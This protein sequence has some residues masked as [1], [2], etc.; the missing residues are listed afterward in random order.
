[1]VHVE[2]MIS[3]VNG[4][5]VRLKGFPFIDL[6]HANH[7]DFI[8]CIDVMNH[9]QTS[10]LMAQPKRAFQPH[11]QDEIQLALQTSAC[12]VF[13]HHVKNYNCHSIHIHYYSTLLAMAR[14]YARA[15]GGIR[16]STNG[17]ERIF[18]ACWFVF[19]AIFR[20]IVIESFDVRPR[21][22]QWAA[23]QRRCLWVD[24]TTWSTRTCGTI[25]RNCK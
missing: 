25:E 13:S 22:E 1:M 6:C 5:A 8:C 18:C 11:S 2:G 24:S 23:N 12:H 15:K 20:R 10:A 21:Y 9:N 3:F 16:F 14:L 19:R 4:L 17:I 7:V